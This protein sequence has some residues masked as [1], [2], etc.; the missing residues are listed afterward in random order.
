M[1]TLLVLLFATLA[2]CLALAERPAEW[3]QPVAATALKNF[4]K[5]SD[6]LYRCAQPDK[7]GMRELEKLGIRTVINLRD[8]HDD[9]EEATGT[10]LRLLQVEMSVWEVEPER[11]A[12]VLALLREKEHGP[13]VIHCQHG[14]DRTGLMCAFYRV[15]EQGW[16]REDAIREMR[17]GGYGFHKLLVNFVR[18]AQ[19]MD[20]EKVR[21]RVD[22]LAPPK[23]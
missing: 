21:Q 6:G 2:P 18:H 10:R 5:V 7:A 11:L 16:K 20:I 15:V 19:R 17:E 9:L 4:H 8:N 12:R 3:A 14:S 13:F 22:E 1:R 23:P